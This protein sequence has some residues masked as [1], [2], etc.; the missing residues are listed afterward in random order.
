LSRL[1]LPER[2]RDVAPRHD[3]GS[4]T[5]EM[6]GTG[7]P[8]ASRRAEE[9]ATGT[10]VARELLQQRQHQATPKTLFWCEWRNSASVVAVGV[11]RDRQKDLLAGPG[12]CPAYS[13]NYFVVLKIGFDGG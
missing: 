7:R 6:I 1:D 11:R 9:G 5:V 13:D 8:T 4:R 12:H 2:G 3:I 10:G